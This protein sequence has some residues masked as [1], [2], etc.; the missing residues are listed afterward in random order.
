LTKWGRVVRHR[1]ARIPVTQ[2]RRR[3]R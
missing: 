1:P 2:F 3:S